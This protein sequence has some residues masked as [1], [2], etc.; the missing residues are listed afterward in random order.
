MLIVYDYSHCSDPHSAFE[1][2]GKMRRDPPEGATRQ[3][4]AS[5]I[6]AIDSIYPYLYA[7]YGD[8]IGGQ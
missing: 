1:L 5:I 4:G 7:I 6:C 2:R 3:T 8:K